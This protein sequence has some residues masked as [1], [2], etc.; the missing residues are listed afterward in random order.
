MATAIQHD[1]HSLDTNRQFDPEPLFELVPVGQ[2]N[3]LAG[4]ASPPFAQLF[5]RLAQVVQQAVSI[6]QRPPR[7]DGGRPPPIVAELASRAR[8]DPAGVGPH[9]HPS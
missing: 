3:R 6:G 8:R 5:G 9:R 1:T 7:R 4:G 2:G